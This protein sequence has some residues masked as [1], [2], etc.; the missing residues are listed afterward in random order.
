MDERKDA[1]SETAE[2]LDVQARKP[3]HAPEFMIGG[4]AST[5]AVLNGGSDGA[6][7]APSQS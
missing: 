3:W 6:P 4:L 1:G 7:S 5:N 2:K